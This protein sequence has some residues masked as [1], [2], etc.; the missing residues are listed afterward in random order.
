MF[1]RRLGLMTCAVTTTPRVWPSGADFATRS[2]P[3]TVPAPGRFS[4]TTGWPQTSCIFAAR[5]RP[6]MSVAPP[7]G[8][9]TIIR[10]GF[11]G[12]PCAFPQIS[13]AARNSRLNIDLRNSSGGDRILCIKPAEVVARA[14][15]A[16]RRHAVRLEQVELARHLA[17]AGRVEPQAH[18]PTLALG[19]G[20]V[21][22]LGARMHHGVVVD[23]HHFAALELESE[24][25]RR[26]LGD[27]VEQVE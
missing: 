11:V 17:E 12:K 22:K 10:T 2:V 9:G 27:F 23:Q 24:P 8:N 19:F 20:M 18:Q 25:V 13:S 21:F 16:L 6:M 4:T 1:G 7:G 5:R 14:L 3:T 15:A 26:R